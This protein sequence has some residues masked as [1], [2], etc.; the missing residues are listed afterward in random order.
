ML[1]IIAAPVIALK[2]T[3]DVYLRNPLVARLFWTMPT[4]YALKV[5]WCLGAARG[6]RAASRESRIT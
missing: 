3:A 6:L 5:A 1:L 2:V 4:V